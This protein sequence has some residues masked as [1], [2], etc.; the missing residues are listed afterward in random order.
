MYRDVVTHLQNL[1]EKHQARRV[2]LGGSEQ[3]AHHVQS[4]MPQTMADQVVAVLP[5]PIHADSKEM[6]ERSQPV[7]LEYERKEEMRLVEQLIDLAKAG[8]RGALGR[9][10]VMNALQQQRVELLLAPWPIDNDQFA[11]EL[12]MLTFASSG[13]IELVHGEAADRLNQ[14]GGLAAP[15]YYAL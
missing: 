11:A 7:A 1:M 10:A 4:L 2:I 5:I 8:G 14:D 3:S 12:V 6:I 15:L 9:K 13:Q